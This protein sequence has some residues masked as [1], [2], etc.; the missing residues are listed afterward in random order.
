M[1]IE[2]KISNLVRNQFPVFYQEE[3]PIFVA[4]VQKYF[5]WLESAQPTANQ[6][7]AEA[8]R[9]CRINV[10]AGNST[11]TSPS[12][13]ATFEACFANGDTIAIY[14]DVE[15]LDYELYTVDTVVNNNVLTLTETPGFSVTSTRYSTVADQKQ[16]VKYLRDFYADRDIDTTADE[17]LVYFKEKYLK[18]I[19]FETQV[20]QRRIVKHA[21]DIYRSKGTER[22]VDLL[23]K[24]A[25][26]VGAKVYYPGD[27]LFKLSDGN[28]YIPRYLEVSLKET[29]INLSGKQIFGYSS[30]ATAFVEAVV[31]KSVRGRLLDVLYISAING[32]FETGELINSSDISLTRSERPKV[33][34][35]LTEVFID[36]NGDIGQGFAVGD[37]VDI[38]SISGEGGQARVS[39]ISNTS[40][41]VN[42]NLLDGGYAYSA[43]AEVLVSSNVF[44]VS[45]IYV[46]P[47][48][49]SLTN[50]Y[51][52]DFE[53]MFQPYANVVYATATP[54]VMLEGED[55]FTYYGNGDIMGT[56][57]VLASSGNLT[58]GY[59][60]LSI[61]SGD[62]NND[63]IYTSGNAKAVNVT[64]FYSLSAEANVMGYQSNIE[65]FVSNKVGTYQTG[66][67]V[68]QTFANS[69]ICAEGYVATYVSDIGSNGTLKLTDCTGIFRNGLSVSA[70]ISGT[71]ANVAWQR[72]AVGVKDVVGDFISSLG[73]YV[74][75]ENGV[76]GTLS[77]IY[78]GSGASFSFSNNLSYTETINLNT[79]F[80]IDYLNLGL[81]HTTYTGTVS[82]STTSDEVTGTG[83]DF[84]N[85]IGYD[86]SG[87]VAF[88]PTSKTVIGDTTFFTTELAEDDI[89]QS[90]QTGQNFRVRRIVNN[91]VMYVNSYPSTANAADIITKNQYVIFTD[92]TLTNTDAKQ[93]VS[94]TNSTHMVVDSNISFTAAAASIKSSWGFPGNT[95]ANTTYGILDD[96]LSNPAVTIGRIQYLTN[97]N[98]GTGYNIAPFV[99]IYEPFTFSRREVDTEMTLTGL[100]G[101]FAP[102]ELVTQEATGARG[103]V[104][105]SNT[106][107]LLVRRLNID[108]ANSFIVTS[109]STTIISGE[110]SGSTANV[111]VVEPYINSEYLGYNANVSATVITGDGGIESVQVLNSG[112][113]FRNG[114]E[115]I[116]S[117]GNNFIYGTAYLGKQGQG[118]GFYRQKGGF[119]SDQKKLFDGLYYQE[120]SYEV[121]SS[122]TLDRYEEMLK[123]LL[124]VAG[125]K[126]FGAFV[127]NTVNEMTTQIANT[128][129]TQTAI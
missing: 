54:S 57:K 34:G 71:T 21:L 18:G 61:E 55:V 67:Y 129:V 106:T 86:I 69:D 32:E 66:E 31:R 114:E 76:Y 7:Y 23:F 48:Y 83:T 80:V 109:N 59:L 116:I 119:L 36:L 8:K 33:I 19:Q 64:S 115:V 42:F 68:Y 41:V 94:I 79:D 105:S 74:Y 88:D 26:G 91:T 111:T 78:S 39:A 50:T 38:N 110:S 47:D 10:V 52:A 90:A 96:I 40:G 16:P 27:D 43:N 121:R 89:I 104:V 60:L 29:N 6:S 5:E 117:A 62:L 70:N 49:T 13:T 46:S 127:Y 81:A 20:D 118:A 22:S 35:S 82:V 97:I 72:L 28:W 84:L 63:P 58:S 1:T 112:F 51:I 4:F 85:E 17:F 95:A 98:R 44:G 65:L 101:V 108:D 87:A 12:N 93:I 77:V 99:K 56:G 11:I 107:Y 9:N 24:L 14:K 102:D 100:S 123:Q 25:F 53:K 3:G 92:G 30:Q 75:F 103:L 45:N 37:L 120:Y 126:Y 2:S 122:I 125:T 73:N 15:G 128:S 113:G 124:H